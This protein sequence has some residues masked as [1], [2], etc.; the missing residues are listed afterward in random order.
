VQFAGGDAAKADTSHVV[1]AFDW[2]EELKKMF[3]GR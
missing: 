3:E 1:L 2:T